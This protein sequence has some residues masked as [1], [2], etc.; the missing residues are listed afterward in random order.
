MSNRFLALTV[1]LFVWTLTTHGKFSI[2][3]D[4]PH[5]LMIAESLLTDR[6]LDLANNYERRDG[7]WFSRPDIEAFPHARPMRT[8]ALWSVHDIGVPVAMLPVYA[9]ATRAA[10]RVPDSVL[11]RVRQTHGLFAYSLMN[12][13][14]A[15][16]TACGAV[17]MANALRRLAPA[18]AP[19]LVALFLA[20][21]PP[22]LSHA[23]LIFPEIFA[24][25]AV[26][27]VVWLLCL[28]DEEVS[29]RRV[30]V[31]LAVLGLLPWFHRKY[32]FFALALLFL[33]VRRHRG[34][35]KRTAFRTRVALAAVF[36]LPQIAL[37]VW[38]FWAWGRWGGPQ[39]LNSLPFTAAGFQTGALG[40]L[41]DREYGL[42][43]YGPIYLIVPACLALF[44]KQSW[45]LLV[46][47]A[48]LYLPMAAFVEWRGGFSPA[49]RYLVPLTPLLA[50]PVA[51]ALERR[52]VRRWIVP[53]AALQIGIS[54]YL[55]NR[56]R[57]LWPAG[58]GV[59]HALDAMPVIGPLYDRLLPSMAAADGIRHA[60]MTIAIV[61]V[62]S[63]VLAMVFRRERAV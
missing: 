3:G 35:L 25:T 23:F 50:I 28:R 13:A 27:A 48:S 40:L 6:D 37:H 26:C 39:M 55:W 22:V 4:E 19:A 44:W 8:G 58:D 10:A 21:S 18:G 47:V 43:G 60:W 61:G 30:V 16:L 38:T 17:L 34:W 52:S 36:V 46:P 9:I 45:D 1:V 51:R 11:T 62:A 41:L 32:S 63:A 2:S 59:N 5:Y 49:A 29:S 42:F 7:E 53:I 54:A 56:P 57:W 15:G 33:I 12:I 20:L 14:L 24:F 31:M